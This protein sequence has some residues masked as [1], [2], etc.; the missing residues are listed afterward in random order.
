MAHKQV[1]QRYIFKIH[2]D[3]LRRVKWNLRLTLAE[4]RRNDE[5]IGIGDSQMLR[6]ID[7]LNGVGDVEETV[8]GLHRQLRRLKKEPSSAEMKRRV[9]RVYDEIDALLFKPDY[10]H[11]VIDR[12]KDLT[13]ACKG[14]VVNGIKYVRLL[15]TPGGI[16]N[17]TVVFVNER[18]ASILRVRIDN[19]RNPNVPL[20]PAKFEA[21][22]A[23]TCSGSTPVSMPR[24]ILVVQDCM[25]QFKEDVRY[26]TDENDGEPE[27]RL[28]RDYDVELDESDG[29]GLMLPSLAERWSE[30][31]GLGY[32][33]GAANCR[34]A[35]T[36]GMMFAFDFIDFADKVAGGRRIVKDAWGCD[37]DIAQVELVLTT[38]ML[39]LWDAYDSLE[40][41]L[42][43]SE[44]NHYTFNIAKVAPER[45]ENVRSLNYQFIQS[46]RLSDEQIDEL[47]KPTIDEIQDVLNR[48]LCKTLLYLG[49]LNITEE[50][51]LRLDN[52]TRALMIEPGLFQ[53]GYVKQRILRMIRRRI[54]EAKIGVI[55]VHGNYSIVCGDP[56]ALC[57]SI[58]G[59]PV[60]G[61]LKAGEIFNRY[62]IDAG[63]ERLACYRAPMSCHA[64]VRLVSVAR[65]EEPEY[66][67]RHIPTCT[68]FNAWDSAAAALNGM[69]KDGDLVMLTDNRVL[70]DNIRPEP[71]LYCVQR[72]AEKKMITE[73]E[74]V[75]SNIASFGC[76]VGRITNRVTAMYDVQSR[77]E[78]GSEEFEAL[79]YRIRCGQLY[80]QSSIDATKG[81]ICKPMPRYWHDISAIHKPEDENDKVAMAEYRLNRS[82]VADKKPY[83]M[84]YVYPALMRDYNRYIK[85]VNAKCLREFRMTI[86]DL[87][88]LP[89][90]ELT[91]EQATFLHYYRKRMPVGTHDCVMNRL[92]RKVESAFANPTRIDDEQRF[93]WE[94]LKTGA[95]YTTGQYRAIK[96]LYAEFTQ[97]KKEIAREANTRN[98]TRPDIGDYNATVLQQF[99]RD[100][101]QVCPN[102]NMLCDV[103]IDVCYAN[104]GSRQFVWDMVGTVIV[105][106]LLR[107][108]S[109]VI[110]FPTPDPD[111]DIVY[112][113][114]HFS[115]HKMEVDAY[116]YTDP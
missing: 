96:Q 74:L 14:F 47:I 8:R 106:N 55:D 81:I 15:G 49:G 33:M 36:K 90:S 97:R 42:A 54:D 71:T 98:S 6:W 82:I 28:V 27:M 17:S 57:Q 46:Y 66:W 95:G 60:T 13:R 89:E 25:T 18:L 112:S 69:D 75:R 22:R 72:R 110:K 93:D 2:S 41:F 9:R 30:E 79:E 43:H 64:N 86:D 53:D 109:G 73:D 114:G 50:S 61:L 84:R 24:G 32:V 116:S 45:L 4:A 77:F 80:Q 88:A 39:K 113:G 68:L 20:V 23:L 34:A 12:D 11:L 31:L 58:F 38:S 51:V 94:R 21:Y 16:K 62:W 83:F 107:K 87:S 7:E 40:S 92:C 5:V 70:V 99:Y 56:Y 103:V 91:E 102:E 85:N 63:S 76:D 44:E 105:E 19:G 104:P 48:D 111:G 101:A 3:R 26:L 115:M 78:P 35:F 52:V 100:A 67:Y 65:G 29:Y 108:N 1:A 59:L 37:V 10:L